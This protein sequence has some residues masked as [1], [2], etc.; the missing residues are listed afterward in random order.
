MDFIYGRAK[1]LRDLALSLGLKDLGQ[2]ITMNYK[3]LI[4]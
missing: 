1:A 2:E 4:N 3:H